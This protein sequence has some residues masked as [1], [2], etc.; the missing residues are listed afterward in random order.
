M[1]SK[2][3]FQ[4]EERMQPFAM[5]GKDGR[6]VAAYGEGGCLHVSPSCAVHRG[7]H[8]DRS[9]RACVLCGHVPRWRFAVSWSMAVATGSRSQHGETARVDEIAC[10]IK[11]DAGRDQDVLE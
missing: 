11:Q 7:C 6:A 1:L 3:R 4:L 10:V 8:R 2:V 9:W 5:A